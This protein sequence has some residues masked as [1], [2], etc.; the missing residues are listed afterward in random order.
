M[1]I[2]YSKK[3]KSY[4]LWDDKEFVSCN[5]CHNELEG[6][7]VLNTVYNELFK[8]VEQRPYCIS[9]F[10]K[11]KKTLTG[12]MS[13]V[14]IEFEKP[15]DL[16]PVMPDSLVTRADGGNVHGLGGVILSENQLAKDL[17]NPMVGLETEKCKVAFDPGRN[18]QKLEKK[19][20]KEVGFDWA[21][22]K[23]TKKVEK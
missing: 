23:R 5:V 11:V 12:S 19:D 10:E 9:C 22:A 4:F 16:I 3:T 6:Q 2:G 13:H 1:N 8:N 21:N 7:F 14:F 18:I 15:K 17:E 20:L